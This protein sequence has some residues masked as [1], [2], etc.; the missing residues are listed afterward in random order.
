MR[1]ATCVPRGVLLGIAAG[2]KL[3]R[4]RSVW[5]LLM[6]KDCWHWDPGASFAATVGIGLV[7]P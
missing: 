3:T 6:R 1:P 7:D 4:W 2:I 5:L